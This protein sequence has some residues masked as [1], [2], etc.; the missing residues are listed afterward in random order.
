MIIGGVV[1]CGALS[2]ETVSN[3][4][5]ARTSASAIVSKNDKDPDQTLDLAEVKAAASAH[6][7]KLNKDA[8]QTLDSNDALIGGRR[9]WRAVTQSAYS[10]NKTPEPPISFGKSF[11][12]GNP[13]LILRT[14]SP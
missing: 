6:F 8:D 4:A 10:V 9:C 13:S 12:F 7:D 11:C 1:L 2:L 14:F 5:S 3:T